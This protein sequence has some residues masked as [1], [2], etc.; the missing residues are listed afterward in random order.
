MA[1]EIAPPK[2]DHFEGLSRDDLL[3]AW[4][5]MA[6]SRRI[7]DKEIL[8]KRQNRIFFQISGAGH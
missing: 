5:N 7:D 6:T 4:R 1:T 8:L 3:R 2:A